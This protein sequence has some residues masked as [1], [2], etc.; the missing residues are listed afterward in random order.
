MYILLAKPGSK[1]VNCN[2]FACTDV[3]YYLCTV[4]GIVFFWVLSV[5]HCLKALYMAE[6]IYATDTEPVMVSDSEVGTLMRQ[7]IIR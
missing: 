6:A 1:F 7:S 5:D 3:L 4:I 2:M